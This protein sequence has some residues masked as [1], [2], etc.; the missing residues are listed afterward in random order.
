VDHQELYEDAV[1]RLFACGYEVF[2]D[3]LGYR[4]QHIT[5]GLDIS[6]MRDVN[7]LVDFANLMSWAEQR[8]NLR[9]GGYGIRK[10]KST[11]RMIARQPGVTAASCS[12]SVVGMPDQEHSV[13]R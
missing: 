13:E 1:R 10:P 12:S 4:V 6:L 8:R 7:D 9:G 5:D 11:Y 2:S 3:G